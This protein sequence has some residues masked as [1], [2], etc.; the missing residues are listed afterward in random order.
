MQDVDFQC[1]MVQYADDCQFLIKGKVEDFR[2]I[3]AKAEKVLTKA[4][5]YFD[6]NGLLINPGKTQFIIIGSRQNIARLPED[7]HINFENNNIIPSPSVKNLG[8]YIDRFM[9]FEV[10]VEEVRKKVMGI[11]IFLN[12]IKDSI[13]LTTRTQVFETLPLS[14]INYCLKIWGTA[15]KAQLQKVQVLQNF[16]ARIAVGNIRKYE[17]IT[18]HINKLKWLK[19]SNKC[20]FDTCIY[21]F[22]LL[23]HQLPAW[24]LSL[25]RVR[26]L[27]FRNTRQQ[28][29]L[30]VPP[31]R[32]M[33]GEREMGVR[34]PKLWN[35]LPESVK[36]STSI[37]SF[38]R[39]LKAYLLA[40]Q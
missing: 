37:H 22:K 21:I 7:I 24:L 20:I 33:V 26:E 6:Q 36:S 40:S 25:P 14:I 5:R 2:N 35:S 34:G 3:I 15:N 11:L 30:F 38:K 9:T 17:H 32:T 39:S 12:R 1:T 23:N 13:P 19:M 31:T 28:N 18:P 8:I 4:K 10:H 16:A 27:I 29:N